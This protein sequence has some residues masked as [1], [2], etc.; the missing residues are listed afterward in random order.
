MPKNN[1]FLEYTVTTGNKKTD[2]YGD[3][4]V[5]HSGESKTDS[6]NGAACRTAAIILAATTVMIL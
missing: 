2:A 5:A 1:L 3:I 4:I 6:K